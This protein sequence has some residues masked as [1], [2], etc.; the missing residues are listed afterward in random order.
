MLYA[1][2]RRIERRL[3]D[4]KDKLTGDTTKESR[5]QLAPMPIMSRLQNALF[6]T[7]RQ[8]HGPT[9]TNRDD[10]DIARKDYAALAPKLRTLI[11]KD[12]EALKQKLDAAGVPW[13]SG[14]GIPALPMK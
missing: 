14:R 8:T 3:L 9:K 10:Y 5:E 7:L 4:A 12:F 1:D 6:G 13:T 2:A 11:E